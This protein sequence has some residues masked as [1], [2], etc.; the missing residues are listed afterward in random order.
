LAEKETKLERCREGRVS[1]GTL[2]ANRHERVVRPRTE[3]PQGVTCST[4]YVLEIS[5]WP[6]QVKLELET[7]TSRGEGAGEE[8]NQKWQPPSRIAF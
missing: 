2:S 6:L 4:T 8:T 5:L 7:T 3:L 1:G